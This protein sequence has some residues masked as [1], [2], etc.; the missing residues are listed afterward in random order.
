VG[1]VWW[2]FGMAL[3]VTYVVF[4]YGRFKGK[5]EAGAGH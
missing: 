4:V 2:I 3:A 5:V 1:L